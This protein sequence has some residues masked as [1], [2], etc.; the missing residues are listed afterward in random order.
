LYNGIVLPPLIFLF[1]EWT[2]IKEPSFDIFSGIDD[3]NAMWV[4]C[5]EGLAS[6]REKME[7]IAA[8]KPGPYFIFSLHSRS[9]LAKIETF[10]KLQASSKSKSSAA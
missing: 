7:Q 5:V 3:K 2:M 10:P 4:A 8:E 1:G 6:A 9:I